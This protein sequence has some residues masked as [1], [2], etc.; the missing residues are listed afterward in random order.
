MRPIAEFLLRFAILFGLLAWPWPGIET[1]LRAGFRAQTHLIVSLTLPPSSFHV[2][3]FSDPRHPT[4]DTAVV[5]PNPDTAGQTADKSVM[6]I[7]FDSASQGWIPFA[8]FIA[9]NLATPMPW[10]KRWKALVVG[11]VIIEFLVAA[12]I[13]VGVAFYRVSEN[14]P[15][16]LPLMFAHRLLIENIWFSFVP[17]FLLWI[18]SLAWSGH[19]KKLWDNFLPITKS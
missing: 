5:L 19:W 8:M 15:F 17:P 13:W 11:V 6:E 12:T 4:L 1:A 14:S 10:I 16:Q 7:P 9:L 18:A 2:E 3:P